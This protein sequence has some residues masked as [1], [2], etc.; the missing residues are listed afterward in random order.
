MMGKTM[1]QLAFLDLGEMGSPMAGHS[2]R[3]LEYAKEHQMT[4]SGVLW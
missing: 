3:D 4:A 2:R 1:T